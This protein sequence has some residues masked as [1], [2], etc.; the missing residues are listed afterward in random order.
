MNKEGKQWLPSTACF[1][2]GFSFSLGFW[3]GNDEKGSVAL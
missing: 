2:M 1:V 3:P